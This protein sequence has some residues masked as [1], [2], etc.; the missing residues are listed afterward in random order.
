MFP[1]VKETIESV[2]GVQAVEL[3]EQKEEGVIDNRQVIVKYDTGFDVNA[4]LTLLAKEGFDD[5]EMVQ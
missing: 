3:A 2:E 4:A 5:S 1:R